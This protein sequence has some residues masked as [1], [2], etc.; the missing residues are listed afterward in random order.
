MPADAAGRYAAR[1]TRAPATGM[2]HNLQALR[3]LAAYGVVG[4]HIIDGLRNYIAIGRVTVNPAVGATGVNIFFVISGFLM[5]LTTSAR[6]VT[7]RA[8]IAHRIARVVPTYWL[9][10]GL[11]T[12]LMLA[13]FALFARTGVDP[14]AVL[15]SLA[16]LPDLRAGGVVMKPLLF[17]GWTLNYEMMFYAL[18]AIGLLL[19]TPRRRCLAT[20]AA[21]LLLWVAHLSRPDPLLAYWGDDIIIAFALGMLLWGAV[22]TWPLPRPVA[23]ACLPVSLVGLALPDLVPALAAALHGGLV[24]TAAAGL[25][26]FAAVSLER[27]GAS[28]GSGWLERQGDAS[29]ALYLVHPFVLQCVG[30]LAIV[31]GLNRTAAGLGLTVDAM[32]IASG[33]AA[34]IFHRQ[35]ERPLARRLRPIADAL[36]AGRPGGA[37]RRSSAGAPRSFPES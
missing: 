3:A 14:R 35:V 28:V 8:F 19:P 17:V 30:K 24:V 32:L 27:R 31:S 13:G 29:Y 7:P 36:S 37:R 21:I 18:F 9:L 2:N 33:I 4:H 20:C 6:P 12:L 25:L 16:F 10:T 1:V 11:A 26:V 5:M 15:T 22:R 23:L 34:T